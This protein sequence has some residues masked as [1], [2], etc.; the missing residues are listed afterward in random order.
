LAGELQQYFDPATYYQK[1]ARM[2][3]WRIPVA[4]LEHPERFEDR[5][6]EI[7]QV[8]SLVSVFAK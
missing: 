6:R 3:I 5:S 7:W 8:T 2:K 4:N 1:A